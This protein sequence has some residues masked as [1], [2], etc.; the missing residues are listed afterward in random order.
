[1]LNR[2]LLFVLTAA[3]VAGSSLSHAQPMP[4]S[5]IPVPQNRP[6][7]VSTYATGYQATPQTDA[8][9]IT[10]SIVRPLNPNETSGRASAALRQGL[11]AIGRNM[12]QARSIRDG[13]PN[14]SL[15][16]QILTWAIALSGERGV[17]SFEIASAASQ[18]QGWPGL[19]GLR[20]HSERALYHESPPA[21]Q[22]ISAFSGSDPSTTEGTIVLAKALIESGQRDKARQLVSARWHKEAMNV[23]EENLILRAFDGLLSTA[24]HKRR[25]DMLLY[26]DRVSQA[27]RFATRGEAQSLF[28]ARSGVIRRAGNAEALLKAVHPSWHNDPSYL[29]ARIRHLRHTDNYAAAAKLLESA[30]TDADRLVDPDAW[31]N[32]RRIVSRGVLDAGD[33]RTAYRIA[34][35][36][37]AQGAVDRVD[38]EFHS[39][40]FALRYIGDAKTAHGHFQNIIN[41]SNRPLSVSRGYYWLGRAA[42]AGGPGN[43]REYYQRAARHKTTYYGQLAAAKLGESALNVAYPSPSD[44]ER[45]RFATRQAAT[46]IRRLEDAGHGGRANALYRAM[47]EELDSPGELALL[48]HMAEQRGDHT[49]ALRVGKWAFNRG[50][51]VAALAFPVGVIPSNANIS[52][53][54][55][56]LAYA[57]ARQESEFNKAAV[58]PADARGL[59]QLLPGTAKGVA[60]RH[61]LSYAAARLTQDAGYNA[62]LGAHYLGEQIN[63]FGGSYIMTFIAYNAGPRRV[64]QWIA[65]YGDPR[66]KS[67][68]EVIDWVERIPFPE[69]RNYVQRVMENYQVYKSRLGAKTDIVHDLRFGRT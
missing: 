46:A 9:E 33:A 68:E 22:V 21:A 59:L 32:E 20:A 61:G 15:D 47:A 39:G 66:G 42:E 67:I 12:A 7:A 5:S 37:S 35:R 16:R 38:A 53:A 8:A 58:S 4:P 36:H 50:V 13:M 62:T 56:A 40:F 1:M 64:P 48:A 23:N 45:N 49:T 17:P 24:D 44:A 19:S 52:G 11:D 3:L 57:I 29:H 51:D 25:M 18:L 30:P 43:A 28:N 6:E 27:E 10:G 63:D 55:K 65:R 14:G 41:I 69:T 60:S 26:R 2:S 34:S 54:G 31:W